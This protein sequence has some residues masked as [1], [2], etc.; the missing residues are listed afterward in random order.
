MEEIPNLSYID[1]LAKGDT[2]F[3]K[4]LMDIIRKELSTEIGTYELYLEKDDFSKTAEAVHKLSHKISI[5]GLE[6]GYKIAKAYEID[7]LEK[8]LS[9]RSDFERI[10]DA[11][12]LFIQKV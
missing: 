9:L 12:L 4:N 1:K 7:L 3:A 6:K 11:M 2:L 5:L 8:N 10:L